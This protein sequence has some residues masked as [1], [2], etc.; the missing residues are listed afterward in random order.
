[1]K[2]G[3]PSPSVSRTSLEVP[4]IVA[5]KSSISRKTSCRDHS[6]VAGY[7]SRP[8]LGCL[9][10]QE[11]HR[12]QQAAT[13]DLISRTTRLPP[14]KSV[15]PVDR[16]HRYPPDCST[17]LDDA[18]RFLS[19]DP[20][21]RPSPSL[22]TLAQMFRW[23]QPVRLCFDLQFHREY[24]HHRYPSNRIGAICLSLTIPV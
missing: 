5:P 17:Q 10:H 12:H 18:V 11:S 22:S 21:C 13:R 16:R 14:S 7:R 1:M 20:S 2:S 6:P 24:H 9:H 3:S 19:S 4:M 15:H 8:V 23:V